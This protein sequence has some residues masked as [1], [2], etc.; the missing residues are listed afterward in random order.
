MIVQN[1]RPQISIFV[2]VSTEAAKF[3]T[4]VSVFETLTNV[5][6]GLDYTCSAT[7]AALNF[8]ACLIFKGLSNQIGLQNPSEK[9][10]TKFIA[11]S[12]LVVGAIHLIAKTTLGIDS[13]ALSVVLATSGFFVLQVMNAAAD[14]IVSEALLEPLEVKWAAERK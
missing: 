7:K 5:F 10:I 8:T 6:L 14:E 13:I 11:N 9:K 4:L 1:Y 3:Y 2:H 12:I